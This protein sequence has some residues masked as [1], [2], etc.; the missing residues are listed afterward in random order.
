MPHVLELLLLRVTVGGLIHP[1]DAEKRV[2][3]VVHPAAFLTD[4]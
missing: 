3:V 2:P 1:Q 4:K